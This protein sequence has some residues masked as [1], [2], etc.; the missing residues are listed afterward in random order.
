MTEKKIAFLE[1]ILRVDANQ[2]TLTCLEIGNIVKGNFER[3]KQKANNIWNLMPFCFYFADQEARLVKMI[4]NAE[5]RDFEA[6]ERI[7]ELE[8]E[9]GEL[10]YGV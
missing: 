10:K 7:K 4:Y 8:Q 2:A 1:Q 5:D 6:N 9:I 3:K